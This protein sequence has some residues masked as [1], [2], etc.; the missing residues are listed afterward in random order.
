M[1]IKKTAGGY[2]SSLI[3]ILFLSCSN[4][5]LA[6]VELNEFSSEEIKTR[7]LALIEELRCPKCQNQNLAGSDSEVAVDLRREVFFMLEDGYSDQD[8]RDFMHERYGDFILYNPPM[9]GKTLLV[10]VLPVLFFLCGVFAA[11]FIV[12]NATRNASLS[13]ETD[14]TLDQL[15]FDSPKDEA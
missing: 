10:W 6:V 13:D 4:V 12:R 7:Y 9:S 14:E 5:A 1:K 2:L 8:I 3:L 15:D 11:F